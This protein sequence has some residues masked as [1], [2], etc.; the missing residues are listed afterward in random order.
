MQSDRELLECFKNDSG[1]IGHE[2][3]R[4]LVERHGPMVLGLC[5]SLVRD[6]HEA[7]DAFQATFLVLVGKARSIERRD[8]LGPWLHG[9]AAKVARRARGR[10]Q[11]RR[12]REVPVVAELQGRDRA[13][14]DEFSAQ[15][16]VHEEIARLPDSF[17]KPLVLCC[18]QG[19]SYD[20]AAQQLG[21]NPSALRGRLERA[22]KRLSSRLRHR[23]VL[24]LAGVPAFESL[25]AALSP[26]PSTLIE[27][28]VQFSLRWSRV[29]GL[30]G[31][32]SVVP[33]SIST[34]AQGVIQS[35]L[36][37]T[38]R[39]SAVALLAAGAIGTVARAKK[40]ASA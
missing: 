8:T 40:E 15:A 31:G 27:S 26:L 13:A 10:L 21:V 14:P 16:L 32:G 1:P 33:E 30:L 37:Q 35:M 22:R 28:T 2:A 19:L 4:I 12:R 17:R 20:L 23:G 9:V 29:T 7:E 24:S 3:F 11:E 36:I 38:I 6:Q 5:R 39:V 18:L 34:L 25:P